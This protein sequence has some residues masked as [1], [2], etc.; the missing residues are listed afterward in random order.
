MMLIDTFV[1]NSGIHGSG[2]FARE[3]IKA[4][5]RIWRFDQGFDIVLT[6]EQLLTMPEWQRKF[7]ETYAYMNDG[8][9]FYCVDNA[10]FMNHSETPNTYEKPD[11]TY[12]AVDIEIGEELTCNYAA[13]GVTQEDFVFNFSVFNANV[14]QKIEAKSNSLQ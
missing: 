7:F 2:I 8:K 12:A 4:H 10:R 9:L 11:G 13:F 6:P 1:T 5:T 14:S 3:S